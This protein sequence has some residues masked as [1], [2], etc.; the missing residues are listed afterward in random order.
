MNEVIN[1]LNSLYRDIDMCQT[2]I[3]HARLHKNR[4]AENLALDKM[5]RLMCD[6]LQAISYSVTILTRLNNNDIQRTT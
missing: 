2:D 6:A 4:E 3:L 1:E 5:E